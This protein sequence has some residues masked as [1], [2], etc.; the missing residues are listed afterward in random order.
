MARRTGELIDAA[1]EHMRIMAQNG[2]FIDQHTA[3]NDRSKAR[4]AAQ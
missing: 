1:T 3:E 2:G 4:F